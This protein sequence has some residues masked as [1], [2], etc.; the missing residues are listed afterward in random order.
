MS[1][2]Q[3]S[4]KVLAVVVVVGI[5]ALSACQSLSVDQVGTPVAK[6]D[7]GLGDLP[8]YRDWIDP[9]GRAPM[10][11]VTTANDSTRWP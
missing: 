10:G 4:L 5:G 7:N 2:F 9:T 1:K 11:A 3:R 8:N 6:T